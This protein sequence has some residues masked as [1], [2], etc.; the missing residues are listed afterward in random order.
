MEKG[1]SKVLGIAVPATIYGIVKIAMPY[2]GASAITST[3]S[4]IGGGSMEAGLAAL[5]L[6]GAATDFAVENG[7]GHIAKSNLKN[8]L[9]SGDNPDELLDWVNSQPFSD[10]LKDSL[11]RTIEENGGRKELP[12]D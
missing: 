9:Q 11:R 12:G 2:K 3:L 7:I 1:I 5:L 10:A 4:H 6:S 8:R